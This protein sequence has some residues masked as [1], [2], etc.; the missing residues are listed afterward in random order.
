MTT[1]VI[2]YLEMMWTEEDCKAEAEE[3]QVRGVEW[4]AMDTFRGVCVTYMYHDGGTS[5]QHVQAR[6]SSARLQRSRRVK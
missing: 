4:F 6:D 2:L 5:R 3:M 1:T